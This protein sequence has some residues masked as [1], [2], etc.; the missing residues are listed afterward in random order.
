MYR[1][2]ERPPAKPPGSWA[3]AEP[4]D[5]WRARWW[6]RHPHARV[7]GLH[8]RG[9]NPRSLRPEPVA[10]DQ[11]LNRRSPDGSGRRLT[12]PQAR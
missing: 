4:R 12:R 3:D 10:S 7:F 5:P 9:K 11:A 1:F 8:E 6:L 2:A